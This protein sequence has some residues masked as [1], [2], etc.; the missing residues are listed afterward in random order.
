MSTETIMST[1]LATLTP[2]DAWLAKRDAIVSKLAGRDLRITSP[3]GADLAA[4]KVRE[5]R[6]LL[7]EL[8]AARMACTRPLDDAKKDVMRQEREMAAMLDEIQTGIKSSLSTWQAKQDAEARAAE[9]RQREAAAEAAAAIPATASAEEAAALVDSAMAE[10]GPV[11][12]VIRPRG[13]HYRDA[14][15]YTVT[16]RAAIPVGFLAAD[17][18]DRAMVIAH[19]K[20]NKKAGLPVE[21][22]GLEIRI[23]SVPVVR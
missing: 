16:D 5:C 12:P 20:N 15:T 4:G 19:V 1:A 2:E 8:K 9:A 6:D 3:A 7:K 13:T 11:A 22:P 17:P 14:I 21:I 18:T 10:A 23:E